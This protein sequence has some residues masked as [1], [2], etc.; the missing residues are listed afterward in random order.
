MSLHVNLGFFFLLF[1]FVVF[2][3]G[4]GRHGALH[5]YVHMDSGVDHVVAPS[6]AAANP[7]CHVE[8][9]L[10]MPSQTLAPPCRAGRTPLSFL[11]SFCPPHT[12]VSFAPPPVSAASYTHPQ[13]LLL[14]LRRWFPS[15][16]GRTGKEGGDLGEWGGSPAAVSRTK[17]CPGHHSPTSV[18]PSPPPPCPASLPCQHDHQ[19]S[20]SYVFTLQVFKSCLC[21]IF[22]G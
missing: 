5:C 20:R 7:L 18:P 16:A 22:S 2:P 10:R 13:T 11:P 14:L 12:S 9:L 6:A 1:S 17:M 19:K 21:K 4:I 3:L 8:S 15:P